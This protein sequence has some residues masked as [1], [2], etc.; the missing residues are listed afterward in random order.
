MESTTHGGDGWKEKEMEGREA[1]FAPVQVV[2]KDALLINAPIPVGRMLVQ[3]DAAATVQ[4][5]QRP[6]S[7]LGGYKAFKIFKIFGIEAERDSCLDELSIY[8]EPPRKY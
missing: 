4:Y 8:S 6:Q 5:N 3:G 1:H 2:S 7:S